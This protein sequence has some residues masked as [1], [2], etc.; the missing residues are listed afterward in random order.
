MA[1]KNEIFQEFLSKYLSA[2][3]ACKGEILDHVTAVTGMHRKAAVRKFRVLQLRNP[4]QS[5]QR[6]RHTYYT[7]DTTAALR[8]IWDVL[9]Q[10]LVA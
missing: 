5:D 8:D 4:L 3:R 6:G 2:R 10:L 9:N 1:T 7:P